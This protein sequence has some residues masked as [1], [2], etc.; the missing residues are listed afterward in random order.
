MRMAHR[1]AWRASALVFFALAGCA[2][3][4]QAVNKVQDEARPPHRVVNNTPLPHVTLAGVDKFGEYTALTLKMTWVFDERGRMRLDRDA[5]EPV[6]DERTPTDGEAECRPYGAAFNQRTTWFPDTGLFIRGARWA[7][8]KTA[9]GQPRPLVALSAGDH[10]LMSVS[11]PQARE[12]EYGYAPCVGEHRTREGHRA[13]GYVAPGDWLEI[14]PANTARAAPLRL[15]VPPYPQPYVALRFA[16]RPTQQALVPAR[17]VLL[18]LDMAQRRLVLQ[19]QATVAMRPQVSQATW[20]VTQ[21]D[22]ML[23]RVPEKTARRERAVRD[24]L[25]ACIPPNKPMDPCANPHG[26]FPEI[27]KD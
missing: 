13:V 10:G 5:Q 27:L 21:P 25:A 15:Q 8:V 6:I 11:G 7:G 9:S 3:V 1:I 18:T 23:S 26:T 17:I 14:Q 24:Y 4:P 12:I 20:D 19:Y 16:G 22:A 2:P